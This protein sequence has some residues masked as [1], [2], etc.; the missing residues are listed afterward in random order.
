MV[1]TMTPFD[2]LKFLELSN[3]VKL[4]SKLLLDIDSE[5]TPSDIHAVMIELRLALK[6]LDL[7]R[8]KYESIALQ[9]KINQNEDYMNELRSEIYK[10][11]PLEGLDSQDIGKDE[12]AVVS[13]QRL[14]YFFEKTTGFYNSLLHTEQHNKSLFLGASKL[15]TLAETMV[16]G[17]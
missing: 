14:Y 13:K 4:E 11:S 10:F 2:K 6:K 3:K 5:D 8:C 7:V 9:N 16:R 15:R 1:T 12:T 17:E